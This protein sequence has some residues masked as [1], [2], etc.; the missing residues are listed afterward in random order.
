MHL[1]HCSEDE[2]E[3]THW[4]PATTQDLQR[5]TVRRWPTGC[6]NSVDSGLEAAGTR[7]PG[8]PWPCAPSTGGRSSRS[9]R[10]SRTNSRTSAKTG[11]QSQAYAAHELPR[12]FA[13]YQDTEAQEHYRGGRASRTFTT[14]SQG[15]CSVMPRICLA[16]ASVIALLARR[17]FCTA[18]WA[19]P[20]LFAST[21]TRSQGTRVSF[22]MQKPWTDSTAEG[23]RQCL[24]G[25]PTSPRHA[26]RIKSTPGGCWLSY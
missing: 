20:L 23:T 24:G 18:S 13:D 17:M 3:W 1:T 12:R 22:P 5:Q 14:S 11:R 2:D 19:T 26:Q 4:A 25:P 8:T 15:V 21:A 9:S 7:P 16:S 10:S 6:V